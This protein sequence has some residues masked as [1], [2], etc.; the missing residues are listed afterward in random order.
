ML[1]LFYIG[2]DSFWK[3]KLK[4]EKSCKS[5]LF[6]ISTLLISADIQVNVVA[7]LHRLGL[8]LEVLSLKMKKLQKWSISTL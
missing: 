7:V 1:L 5:A 2:W 3:F 6:D 8:I 4:D